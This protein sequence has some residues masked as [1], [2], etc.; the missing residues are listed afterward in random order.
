VQAG[1]GIVL[2]H[3]LA[4]DDKLIYRKTSSVKQTQV[5]K[6]MKI[7]THIDSTEVGV[8][9][10]QEVDDKGNIKAQ[11]E[12]K[13]L[14]VK[15]KIG[16]LGDYTFDSKSND[17]DKGST[18]GAALTPIYE[19][20]S[21][22]IM[23]VTYTPRGEVTKLEGYEELIKDVLKDNPIG[24]QFAGGGSEKA[25]RFGYAEFFP[26]FGEEAVRAGDR[27]ETPYE[28]QLPK[29][30][31]AKGKKIYTYLG[32]DK[33]GNRKTVKI[34]VTHELDFDLNL[35]VNGVKVTGKMTI[36]RATGTIQFDPEKGHLVSMTSQYTLSGTMN[37]DANGM[38][39]PVTTEQL[40]RVNLELLEK[41]PE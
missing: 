32:P 20:M 41:L 40:Q 19:R 4:K 5:V 38:Q 9:T 26:V 29:V 7:E 24:A 15:T 10:F 28:M 2:R 39:F 8:R 13:L 37:V 1:D 3:K 17:N 12:N 25:A 6:D 34:G 16:P 22:A 11:T 35:D 30:G 23:T 36:D 27:W 33:V 14:K 18:L 21:G 31:D